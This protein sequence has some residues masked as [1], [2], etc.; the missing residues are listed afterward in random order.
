M[1]GRLLWRDL[2]VSHPNDYNQS[3]RA[4]IFTKKT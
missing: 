3:L 2:I 4:I 1:Q